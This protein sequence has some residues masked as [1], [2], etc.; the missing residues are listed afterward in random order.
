MSMT[1]RERAIAALEL[2]QPD[3]IPHFELAFYETERDF[4]GRTFYGAGGCPPFNT[5]SY[6]EAIAHNAQLYIDIAKKFDHSIICLNNT[7]PTEYPDMTQGWADLVRAIKKKVGDEYLV[8]CHGD[9][10]YAI[11]MWGMEEFCERL[12]EDQEGLHKEAEDELRIWLDRSKILMDAGMDGFTLCSDYAF[13]SGPFLSPAMFEEFV[14]PYLK[15]L[16]AGQREMGAYVI[17]HTDGDLMPVL[18]MIV[19]AEPHALHSIDPMAGMDIKFIKENY[20][21]RVAL[22]GNVHC[23]HMQTGTPEQIRESTEYC[24]T[25]AK[26]GGGYIFSSSNCVFKGMPMESYDIIHGLWMKHREYNQAPA[27]V[28]AK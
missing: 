5:V 15:R 7:N 14:A 20:G 1:H 19:D 24:L 17:K 4:E 23:A 25:W 22:C 12:A 10:T 28:K 27:E 9:S 21:D 13:N 11:P 3:H 18:D 16:V 26:P 8:M 6:E 2:R